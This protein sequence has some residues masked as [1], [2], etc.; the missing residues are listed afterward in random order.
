MCDESVSGAC[1]PGVRKSV[2]RGPS[3]CDY[4]RLR[5]GSGNAG[6]PDHSLEKRQRGRISRV[7]A[8]G[9]G[10][11]AL[12]T[13]QHLGGRL[14]TLHIGAGYAHDYADAIQVW[15]VGYDPETACSPGG[16]PTTDGVIHSAKAKGDSGNVWPVT[17]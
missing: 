4:L 1:E 14:R 3:N 2:R 5:T 16:G 7:Q 12:F 9:Q 6:R 11:K 17:S 10:L 15:Q 8:F 13:E